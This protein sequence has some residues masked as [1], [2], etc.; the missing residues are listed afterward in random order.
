MH[1][2]TLAQRPLTDADFSSCVTHCFFRKGWAATV[3]YNPKAKAE[4]DRFRRRGDTLSLGVCNGC[5]L[6]ALLGWV[7]EGEDGTG[8]WRRQI[9]ENI[10]LIIKFNTET[11][12]LI[13]CFYFYLSLYFS[14]VI[15]SV[16]NLTWC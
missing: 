4:F 12:I 13:V 14:F 5:Q 1:T 10:S 3:A 9:N 2:Y 6:L 8:K 7:G 15:F 16:Q 11:C